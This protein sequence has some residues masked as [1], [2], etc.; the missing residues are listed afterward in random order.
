V[1]PFGIDDARDPQDGAR[2]TLIPTTVSPRPELVRL[3][4]T[5]NLPPKAARKGVLVRGIPFS[6]G[7]ISWMWEKPGSYSPRPR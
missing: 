3:L 6:S 4:Q 7:V 1:L 2:G 5:N